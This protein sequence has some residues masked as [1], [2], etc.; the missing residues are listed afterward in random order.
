[1]RRAGPRDVQGDRATTTTT[2]TE[3][4][5]EEADETYRTTE[6]EDVHDRSDHG[7]SP[8]LDSNQGRWLQSPK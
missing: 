8:V 2:T 6:H 4:E 3:K 1:M 7:Y 5:D